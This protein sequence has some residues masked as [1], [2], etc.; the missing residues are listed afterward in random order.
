MAL[1]AE[2]GQVR[3]ARG[4]VG[5]MPTACEGCG[6]RS[7]VTFRRPPCPAGPGAE[8]MCFVRACACA[9]RAMAA[10]FPASG[11]LP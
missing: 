8:Q 5:Y 2:R 4:C 10:A 7:P 6:G 11:A 9:A 1:A 3:A